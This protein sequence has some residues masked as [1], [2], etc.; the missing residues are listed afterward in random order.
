MGSVPPQLSITETIP[1]PEGD[2]AVGV[3]VGGQYLV[4]E[5]IGLSGPCWRCAPATDR[6]IECVR[7]GKASPWTVLQHSCT[8][9]VE[10]YETRADGSLLESVVLCGTLEQRL[11]HTAA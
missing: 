2:V 3:G 10:I 6:A 11:A 7:V 5:M 1:V 4:M 9:T 8:G